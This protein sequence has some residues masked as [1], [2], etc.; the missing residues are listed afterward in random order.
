MNPGLSGV[1]QQHLGIDALPCYLRPHPFT[2]RQPAK[3]NRGKM[4]AQVYHVPISPDK[5]VDRG[6]VSQRCLTNKKLHVSSALGP[7]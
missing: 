1:L 4:N 5:I 7:E 6:R 3:I 2:S